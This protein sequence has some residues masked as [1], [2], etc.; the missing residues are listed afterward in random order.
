MQKLVSAQCSV[1][2]LCPTKQ[3]LAEKQAVLYKA[4]RGS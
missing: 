3:P 2:C 1:R 4:A